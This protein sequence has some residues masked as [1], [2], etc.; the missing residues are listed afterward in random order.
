MQFSLFSVRIKNET[1][2][3][4]RKTINFLQQQNQSSNGKKRLKETRE[5][6][7]CLKMRTKMVREKIGENKMHA[8]NQYNETPSTKR[9]FF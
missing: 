4:R 7:E 8:D 5:K 9:M 6:N 3:K 2:K 1:A